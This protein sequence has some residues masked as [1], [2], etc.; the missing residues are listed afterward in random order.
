MDKIQNQSLQQSRFAF[1][2]KRVA[3][4]AVGR[5]GRLDERVDH[6]QRVLVALDVPQ[7]IVAKGSSG[8]GQVQH[9]HLIAPHNK[10]CARFA[11]NLRLGITTD[12][13]TGRSVFASARCFQYVRHTVAPCLARARAAHHKHIGVVLVPVSVP[14]DGKMLREDEIPTSFITVFPCNAEHISPT[15]GTVFLAPACGCCI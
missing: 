11:Q 8:T 10:Q 14:A 15:C 13:G 12:N 7:R 4:F 5:C 1:H 9:T 6:A 3:A 2:P